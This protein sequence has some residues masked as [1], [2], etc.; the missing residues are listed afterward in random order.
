MSDAPVPPPPAPAHGAAPLGPDERNW[1]M[2]AHLSAFA[3]LV[4]GLAV[5]GPLVV[6][7]LKR[8]DHPFVEQHAREALNFQLTWLVGGFVAGIVAFVLFFATLGFG[9]LVIVPFALVLGGLWV[10][11]TIRAAMAASR[12]EPYRYPLTVRLVS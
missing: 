3:A 9:V 4:V 11:W 1:A 8:E 5:L 7:L 2:I 12:G 10:W 6:W